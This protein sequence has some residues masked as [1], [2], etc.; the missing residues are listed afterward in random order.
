M[1]GKLKLK[2]RIFKDIL[3]VPVLLTEGLLVYNSNNKPIVVVIA[4]VV[5]IVIMIH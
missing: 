2:S 1:T 3:H 5:V 4:I